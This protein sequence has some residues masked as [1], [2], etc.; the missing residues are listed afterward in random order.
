MNRNNHRKIQV[1]AA[2]LAALL[3]PLQIPGIAG[4]EDGG[5]LIRVVGRLQASDAGALVNVFLL[6]P[7]VTPEQMRASDDITQYAAHIDI[8]TAD[9]DRYFDY[10]FRFGGA[11]GQYTLYVKA[12]STEL[13]R[14]VDPSQSQTVSFLPESIEIHV[15]PDGDDNAAGTEDAPL[16]TMEG[17]I[18]AVREKK[19]GVHPVEV[20]FHEGVYPFTKTVQL[21]A[22]D[23]GDEDAEIT[24][25]AAEGETV[26]FTGAK[27]LDTDQFQPVPDDIK[28]RLPEQAADKV[29]MMK[30]DDS[31][32]S[33]I[34]M[35]NGLQLGHSPV[36]PGF[37]LNDVRQDLARWPNDGFLPIPEMD[38]MDWPQLENNPATPLTAEQLALDKTTPDNHG[39][40]GR[41][42]PGDH[43]NHAADP[44]CPYK[45]RVGA[46]FPYEQSNPDNW[47]AAKD[48]YVV[49]Y[50]RNEFWSE[51]AK[52]GY[53]DTQNKK[54][55]LADRTQYGV[56]DT[57]HWY[58]TNLLEEID[59]PGEWYVDRDTMMF[60][61][62]PPRDLSM[63]DDTFELAVLKGDFVHVSGADNLRFVGLT[64]DKNVDTN[65]G[66]NFKYE[67]SGIYVEQAE[68]IRILDC[69]FKN[70]A[71]NA[72]WLQDCSNIRID[73]N[74]MYYIGLSGIVAKDCGD[75]ENLVSG[76]VVI[77]NN[78]LYATSMDD[79]SSQYQPINIRGGVGT[80]VEHNL[81][82][83]T[84]AGSL[85]YSGNEN[86]IRYNEFYNAMREASDG[87][88][89]YAGRNWTEYG[90]VVEYNY[91]HHYGSAMW[92][93]GYSPN[94]MFWDD[95]HS[96]NLFRYNIV[97]AAQKLNTAGIKIGGGRNNVAYGNTFVD[98]N[99]GI[100][101]ED[102]TSRSPDG[103]D[104]KDLTAEQAYQTLLN[105]YTDEYGT[106]YP[107]FAKDTILFQKYP[108]MLQTIEDIDTKGNKNFPIGNEITNNLFVDVNRNEYQLAMDSLV[109]RNHQDILSGY[110]I[111]VDAQNQDFRVKSS[112]KASDSRIADDVL[113]ETFDI[114]QIG[115]EEAMEKPNTAFSRLYP[116]DRAVNVDT[117][118]Y[119]MWEP[120]LFADQYHYQVATDPDFQNIVAQDSADDLIFQPRVEIT[121]LQE[122]TR[123]YW[124]VTAENVSRS[125]AN[126]WESADGSGT[127]TTGDT[128][129]DLQVQSAVYQT[130]GG[131]PVTSFTGRTGSFTA[132]LQ[133]KNISG[134]DIPVQA[135]VILKG[136]DGGLV[137]VSL[138]EPITIPAGAGTQTVDVSFDVS[139]PAQ[140]GM[141]LELY[142]WQNGALRPLCAAWE[143]PVT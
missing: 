142:L 32:K 24:Y 138:A 37:Y 91:L 34:D 49:G 126:V 123:Y 92:A 69:I 38:A 6:K 45:C 29:V 7:G 86:I 90:T 58:I 31:L 141:T 125:M 95:L 101:A 82:H 48:A 46:V 83:R 110:N 22:Q 35:T 42:L 50:L 127:F 9:D 43:W 26:Q 140:P 11:A 93:D 85:Y 116:A 81:V 119:L 14:T 56:Y 89:I 12:G 61:Y 106:F 130:S 136:T 115:L 104:F 137:S 108:Q 87:G 122:N 52:L 74:Q 65:N 25:R 18:A 15:S 139:Q 72:V 16:A 67:S 143:L 117:T 64:F 102:R 54:I 103:S 97:Y 107:P 1:L 77:S 21:T 71:K 118:T 114:A 2:I 36:I 23:A 47:T 30:L 39:G 79:E 57:G 96:G 112:A 120:A 4:A 10:T 109:I 51:W 44:D 13:E 5:A 33:I 19:D 100:L 133:V 59:L 28:A 111:F 41:Y 60:Y 55:H 73:G 132:A 99:H 105:G 20:I 94:A 40:L 124:R 135:W 3:L 131:Q 98:I 8:T 76:E 80:V 75:R 70:I 27:R 128:N 134:G 88:I 121:G 78:H 63:E 17:A 129:N 68:N 113:D 84:P 66:G 62:Y 53:V